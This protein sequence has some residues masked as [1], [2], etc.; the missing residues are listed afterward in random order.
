V[1][2]IAGIGSIMSLVVACSSESTGE[3]PEGLAQVATNLEASEAPIGKVYGAH[4]SNGKPTYSTPVT[5]PASAYGTEVARYTKAEAPATI[6]ARSKIDEGLEAR[7]AGSSGLAKAAASDQIEVLVTFKETLKIPRFPVPDE[8]EAKTSAKNVALAQRAQQLVGQIESARSAEHARHAAELAANY[9]ATV[10]DKFWLINGLTARLP[11]GQVRALAA[12]PDVEFVEENQ[13]AL[14]PPVGSSLDVRNLFSSDA[15]FNLGLN[16]GFIGLLDTGIRLT[17]TLLS[18]VSFRRDC[19]NG[20][21]NNCTT[22]VGLDPSDNFWNHGTSSASE[23]T[24]NANLGNANRGVSAITVDSFKV[25]DNVGLVSAAAVRGF[26]A[27]VAVLDRVIVAEIQD[28]GSE[29]G[30]IAAAADA[31][32]DAGAVIVAAAGNFGPG[33]SSVR[34]P[35]KAHKALAIGAVDVTSLALQGFSGRGP[36]T[37]NRIKPDLTGPTNVTAASNAS[38][39]ALHTFGGTSAATPNVAGAVGLVR[40]FLRGTATEF[41]PGQVDAFMILTGRSGTFDNNS[42][43]GLP[44]LPTNGHLNWGSVSIAPGATVDVPIAVAGTS[45]FI[46]VALWWPETAAQ[47]HNDVDLRLLNPGGTVLG[48]STSGGS[49]FERV[50]V[51]TTALGTYNIRISAFSVTTTQTVYW[52]I[53]KHD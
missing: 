47:T 36:T 37:D 14:P 40:N 18:Q 2:L 15:Y 42:G 34:S 20:T 3:S 17:H 25:Y 22:G 8:S 13:K 32:F 26:Q 10:G 30:A 11:L 41:P 44:L 28:T 4:I 24:A 21:S 9:G 50:H 23:I 5:L 6:V 39:T 48:S 19:V 35:G 49:I 51:N 43:A 29:T 33:A 27:A 52:A 46:D 38:D 12:R 1:G 16:G 31:A 45:S 53:F 7:L